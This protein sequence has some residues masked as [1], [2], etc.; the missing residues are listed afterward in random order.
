MKTIKINNITVKI[1]FE[2]LKRIEKIA[3]AKKI[4][5]AQAISLCLERVI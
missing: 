2:T 1:S 4:P 5:T 3:Q